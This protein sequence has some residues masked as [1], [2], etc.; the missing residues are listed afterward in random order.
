MISEFWSK[1]G[2]ADVNVDP[3]DES[4]T[5]NESVVD[6]SYSYIQSQFD[7][8]WSYSP[9]IKEGDFAVELGGISG[10]LGMQDEREVF[11]SPNDSVQ[12]APTICYES[13]YG[14]FMTGFIR[15]GAD[16]ILVITNDG[17]WRDTPGYS[18]HLS[19]SSLRAIE[20]RRSL[21]RSANTG[22]SC[23][24]N[25]KGEIL[26]PTDWWV[27]DAIKGEIKTNNKLTFYAKRGDFIGRLAEF[28][29][30]IIILYFFVNFLIKRKDKS[31]S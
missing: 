9:A 21:A 14:E 13:I 22:I 10:S 20:N 5:Y 7:N 28:F 30:I 6:T 4:W 25:Q 16:F 19:F 26:Q 27:K 3:L 17:W 29:S 15:N 12:V 18:Q 23:F 8:S 31:E 24:I 2:E 1:E 11:W